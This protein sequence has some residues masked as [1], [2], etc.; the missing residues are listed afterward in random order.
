MQHNSP[1]RPSR[2]GARPGFEARSMRE[3]DRYDVII[4][5]AGIAGLPRHS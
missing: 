2:R 4:V 3:R 5:G 1:G